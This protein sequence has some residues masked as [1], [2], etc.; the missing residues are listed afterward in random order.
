MVEI[1]T[2]QNASI[3]LDQDLT[4]GVLWRN[5]F[6]CNMAKSQWFIFDPMDAI[7]I[8]VFYQSR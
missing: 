5:F 1:K 4:V 8:Y 3:A 2:V 7:C 6:T